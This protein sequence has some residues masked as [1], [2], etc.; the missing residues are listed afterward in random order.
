MRY[1]PQ[2]AQHWGYIAPEDRSADIRFYENSIN[3]GVLSQLKTGMRVEVEVK[4][5]PT[6]PRAKSVKI[7]P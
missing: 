3:P 2:S 5:T 6:G 4:E 1:D 7:M